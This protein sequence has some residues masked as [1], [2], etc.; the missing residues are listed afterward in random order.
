M[1]RWAFAPYLVVS[2][3]HLG[4]LVVGSAQVS[5]PTKWVLMPA[6]LAAIFLARPRARAVVVVGSV[7]I[8]LSWCG[9]VLLSTPGDIGFVAGLASFLLA[10]V[11][12]LVLF[13]AVLR[14]RRLPVWSLG[15]A[16]W[17]VILVVVISPHL[18]ALGVP[19]VAY[20]IV[21]AA[22]SAAALA[23]SPTVAVGALLFLL[24]D[25]LLVF[26]LFWPD[27]SMVQVDAIIML[28]YLAGQGLIVFGAVTAPVRES[29]GGLPLSAAGGRQES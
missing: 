12:Y 21:L 18:G 5:T 13:A 17:L 3:V 15:Y 8:V 11:A 16:L 20:G 9:D 7:G 1:R 23:T 25:S 2:V 29:T 10:H 14:T 24:S 28:L 27:F 4:A 19:V 6:L 26:K 22:S